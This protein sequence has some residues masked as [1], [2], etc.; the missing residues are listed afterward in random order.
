MKWIK[1][2]QT[3]IFH[4]TEKGQSMME[5]AVSMVLLLILLAGIFDVG[6]AL[7]VYFD[8]QDAAEEGIIYGTSFP[9]DCNQILMRV[10]E[11]IPSQF[12]NNVVNVNIYI[13]DAYSV[14]TSCYTISNSDVYAGKLMQ[15]EIKYNFNVTMPFLG[16]FIGGQTIPM[17]VTS[18]GVVLRPPPPETP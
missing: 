8:F 11:N 17:K 18:T 13:Q 3:N 10:S 15:V 14:Y 9:T 6:R 1:G 7:I 4:K 2:L 5:L 16:T 12:I